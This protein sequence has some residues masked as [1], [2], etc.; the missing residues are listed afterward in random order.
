MKRNMSSKKLSAIDVVIMV[1]MQINVYINQIIKS[2]IN[3]ISGR[4]IIVDICHINRS[5]WS[6]IDNFNKEWFVMF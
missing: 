4:I 2:L 3:K 5:L 6:E 1:I